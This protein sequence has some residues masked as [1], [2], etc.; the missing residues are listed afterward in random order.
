MKSYCGAKEDLLK[1]VG[2][3]IQREEFLKSQSRMTTMNLDMKK[4]AKQLGAIVHIHHI[5][6]TDMKTVLSFK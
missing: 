5:H 3:F 4:A 1:C 6:K 2:D